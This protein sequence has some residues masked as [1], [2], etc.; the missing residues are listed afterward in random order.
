MFLPKCCILSKHKIS[1]LYCKA[2]NYLSVRRLPCC[3]LLDMCQTYYDRH[4][5]KAVQWNSSFGPVEGITFS[6]RFLREG[7]V[8]DKFPFKLKTWKWGTSCFNS[9]N[10]H[11]NFTKIF[12][13]VLFFTKQLLKR[14]FINISWDLRISCGQCLC[15]CEESNTLAK[16]F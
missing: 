14:G 3:F 7:V 4:G 6:W 13:I 12:K 2:L 8:S 1:C 15:A 10:I 5:Y 16:S 11:N 9:I